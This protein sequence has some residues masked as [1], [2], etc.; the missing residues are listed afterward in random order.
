LRKACAI[1]STLSSLG[2][3]IGDY[4]KKPL[5]ATT[6]RPRSPISLRPFVLP[7]R[8]P[9]MTKLTG[10]PQLLAY[11]E[12]LIEARRGV[13]GAP[14]PSLEGINGECVAV[15][16][17][18]DSFPVS[19]GILPGW[20]E[21]SFG[22]HSDDGGIYHASGH[23]SRV[24]GPRFGV[25][26]VVGC[27]VNFLKKEIF[28]TLN[29]V[30]LGQAFSGVATYDRLYPTIG[31]DSNVSVQF[32]FGDEPFKFDL[33]SATQDPKYASALQG[34]LPSPHNIYK[35]IDD[36]DFDRQT[37]ADVAEVL[38]MILLSL[39]TYFYGRKTTFD[40]LELF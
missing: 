5:T 37:E 38:T 3:C 22:F 40:P 4:L 7:Q 8:F 2:R 6:A 33:D 11:Y 35:H 29:G 36:E 16:L 9:G 20:S 24:Y 21:D 14:A 10:K 13:G 28:F 18:F 34:A 23:M 31:L 1:L 32:N 15:G 25:G 17:S 27:G 12:V 26:D 39:F 30:N 19:G